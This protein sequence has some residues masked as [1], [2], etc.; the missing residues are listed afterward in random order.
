MQLALGTLA[1]LLLPL[2]AGAAPP[3]GPGRLLNQA[4]Q[5]LASGEIDEAIASLHSAIALRPQ[6]SFAWGLLAEAL[7]WGKA[8]GEETVAAWEALADRHPDDGHRVVRVVRARMA[9]HRRDRFTSAT[10]DW[11]ATSEAQLAELAVSNQ[12]VEVRYA[13]LITLRDLLNRSGRPSEGTARGVE[14]WAL[15]PAPLQGRISRL[16]MSVQQGDLATTTEVCL[17]ILRTDPWAAEACSGLFSRDR[18]PESPDEVE[19]A[20]L[21]VLARISELEPQGLRDLV[22]GNELLKFRKRSKDVEAE[23]AWRRSLL[24]VDDGYRLLDNPHWWRGTF[25]VSAEGRTL[26]AATNRANNHQDASVRL[27]QL[28]ELADQVQPNDASM[29][30][31][32]WRWRVAESAIALDDAALAREQLERIVANDPTDARGWMELAARSKPQVAIEALEKAEAAVFAAD[33]DP[34]EHYGSLGF[35]EVQDRR[36]RFVAELRLRRARVHLDAGNQDLGWRYALDAAWMDSQQSDAWALLADLARRQGRNDFA[37]EASISWLA[38]RV[39]QGDEP[40]RD[41]AETTSA[42]WRPLHPEVSDDDVWDALLAV[43]RTRAEV[44]D[45]KS[46]EPEGEVHPLIGRSM[47]DLEVH[48]LTGEPRRLDDL[49]GQVVVVDF[50]ATWCGPCKRALPEL[51]AAADELAGEE[52]T[53]LLVSVDAER[54]Q[55]ERFMADSTYSMEAVW[56]PNGK[57]TQARWVVKGIPSTFVLDAEGVVQFHHQGYERGNGDR[58]AEQVRSLLR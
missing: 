53:F 10:T 13:A 45:P 55:P 11:V 44:L 56:A 50:W 35:A 52:V 8:E 39:A 20:R 15:D 32:R 23:Q 31:Q 48:A 9:A 30:A 22:L 40:S 25:V 2:A 46:D 28:L 18:W 49:R 51:Q 33:W 43:A 34:W 47:P 36:M 42:T 58:I 17:E 12:P 14:A 38:G 19:Q 57:K 21:Q 29:T 24:G 4:Q 16:L 27:R 5:Q 26:F 37:R 6:E 41:E 7:V 1:L 54:A 3:Q